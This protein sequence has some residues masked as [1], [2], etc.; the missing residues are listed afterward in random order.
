MFPTEQNQRSWNTRFAG[1][2]AFTTKIHRDHRRGCLF[3]RDY[4]AHRV[5][6]L[7]MTGEWPELEVD[8]ING[9]ESDNRWAN[10][11]LVTSAENKKN[12]SLQANNTS[13]V[14]GV[15]WDKTNQRWHARIMV[16]KRYVSLGHFKSLEEAKEARRL[17]ETRLGFSVRHGQEASQQGAMKP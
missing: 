1:A 17:A 16:S 5:A 12:R 15:Y 8:H 10:L 13:G 7:I 3:G 4:Y 6:W 14:N 11:R 2:E 9:V